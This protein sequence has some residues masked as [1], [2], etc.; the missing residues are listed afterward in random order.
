MSDEG[1]GQARCDIDGADADADDSATGLMECSLCITVQWR[2]Q[3]RCHSSVSLM[4]KII[5]D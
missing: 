4:A 3:I 2:D 1:R 5:G